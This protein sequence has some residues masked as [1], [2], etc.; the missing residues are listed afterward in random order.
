MAPPTISSRMDS[1]VMKCLHKDPGRR[2]HSVGQLRQTLEQ[3]RDRQAHISIGTGGLPRWSLLVGVGGGLAVVA[4]LFLL[5]FTGS[6]VE[7]RLG[8]AGEAS[9]Q[10][11]E[12]LYLEVLGSDNAC[13]EAYLRLGELYGEQKR[14][15]DELNL[16]REAMTN[17][18]E[19]LEILN[20]LSRIYLGKM[21][22]NKVLQYSRKA[23]KLKGQNPDAQ[24]AAVEALLALKRYKEA[25]KTAEQLV[26]LRPEEA[27]SHLLL[28]RALKVQ[29]GRIKDA[30][31]SLKQAQALS[32]AD[33]EIAFALAE[34]VHKRD[35]C[36]LAISHYSQ[37]TGAGIKK[38]SAYLALA[39]CLKKVGRETEV[40]S[41]LEKAV[42]V[43]PKNAHFHYRLAK[44]FR[45]KGKTKSAIEEYKA[46][47]E[48]K[49][50][51]QIYLTELADCHRSTGQWCEAWELYKRLNKLRPKFFLYAELMKEADK[52]CKR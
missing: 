47:I 35:G 12:Q 3:E 36:R 51:D 13:V 48:S 4:L 31:Y 10:E 29:R 52:R 17:G 20:R 8:R 46:A 25:E 19:D 26:G 18:V 22:H 41:V 28:A 5:F 15:D 45:S 44:H 42:K 7:S 38:T 40:V 49:P 32:P 50:E 1:I 14:I 2:F 39:D 6:S 33:P 30:L 34:V 27:G 43:F 23:L 37:A 24:R 11:A 9:P 16:Y 21:D